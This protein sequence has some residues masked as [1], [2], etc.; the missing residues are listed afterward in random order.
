M[1]LPLPKA[2]AP[3]AALVA[4]GARYEGPLLLTHY[5]VFNVTMLEVEPSGDVLMVEVKLGR[6]LLGVMLNVFTPTLVLNIISYSTNFQLKLLAYDELMA[7]VGAEQ[8]C[9][10]SNYNIDLGFQELFLYNRSHILTLVY[11]IF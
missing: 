9:L 2:F 1:L 5:E 3:F 11:E 7:E 6:Q 4:S 8:P 10:V